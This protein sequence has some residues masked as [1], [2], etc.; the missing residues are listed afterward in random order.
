MTAGPRAVFFDAGFTLVEP[1]RAVPEVYLEAAA[2]LGAALDREAFLAH[3]GPTWRRVNLDYRSRHPGLE[4]SEALEREAWRHF[5]RAVAAPFEALE[6]VHEAWHDRLVAHFDAPASWRPIE[7]ARE[8]LGTLRRRGIALAVVSNWHRALHRIL[9]GLELD[10]DL[11][12]V[13]TSSDSGRKKPH[14]AIFAE[15]RRRLDLDAASVRHV[16]DSW[17]DDVEGARAAAIEPIW[18][19]PRGDRAPGSPAE[20]IR[21]LTDLLD[22]LG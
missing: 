14:P 13:L 11:D 21:R 4:T 18:F 3:F 22:R 5:T 2:A 1:V 9:A 20:E 15:A 10:R 7:G 17:P 19:N 8:V 12:L 6:R 16:G